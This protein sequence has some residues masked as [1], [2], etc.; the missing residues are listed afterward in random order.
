VSQKNAE[1]RK[2]DNLDELRRMLYEEVRKIHVT[3]YPYNDFLYESP[4]PVI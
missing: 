3:R 2:R 4:D 1:N